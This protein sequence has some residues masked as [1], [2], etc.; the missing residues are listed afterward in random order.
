VNVTDLLDQLY[1]R[2]AKR[3]NRPLDRGQAKTRLR[4]RGAD[5]GREH[6]FEAAADAVAV[7][8]GDDR[9]RIWIVLQ[10]GVVDHPRHLRPGRQIA[11]DIGA[12]GKTL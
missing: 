12:D 7:D 4:C 2:A 10:Q 1:R 8:R 6:Q 3:V 5:V 11:A 9:L